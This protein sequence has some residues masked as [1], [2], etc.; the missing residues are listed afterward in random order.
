M[1]PATVLRG[2]VFWVQLDPIQGSEQKGPRPCVVVSNNIIHAQQ[3]AI[4]VPLTSQ[5]KKIRQHRIHIPPKEIIV[6]PGEKG[7]T[8]DS[9]ALTHQVRV[10][11]FLRLDETRV[12][13]F[14]PAAM[15]SIEAG[16][17]FVLDLV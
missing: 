10:V 9:M 3:I 17:V 7:L 12:A 11:S 13:R 15:G 4:V 5:I 8:G 16:L 6:G 2:D 1:P 14:T